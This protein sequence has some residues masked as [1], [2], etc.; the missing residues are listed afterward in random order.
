MVLTSKTLIDLITKWLEVEGSRNNN[1]KLFEKTNVLYQIH[2]IF[3]KPEFPENLSGNT[4]FQN[5]N[6]NTFLIKI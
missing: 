4:D 6:T 2:N 1:N 3:F 5:I